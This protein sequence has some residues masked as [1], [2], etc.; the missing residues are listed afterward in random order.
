MT[1]SDQSQ[2]VL[3]RFVEALLDNPDALQVDLLEGDRG[4]EFVVVKVADEDRGK[5]VGRDG[6]HLRSLAMV[7]LAM[8]KKI[9]ERW[10]L[11]ADLPPP[12]RSRMDST[13]PADCER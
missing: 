2:A 4:V 8:G 11:R 7:A 12:P 5:I 1:T 6:S 3:Q 9:G 10:T 13:R